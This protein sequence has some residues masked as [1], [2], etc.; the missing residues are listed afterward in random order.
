MS[1]LEG[2]IELLLSMLPHHTSWETEVQRGGTS[3]LF[4]GHWWLS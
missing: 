3:S 4:Q 1:E 2:P